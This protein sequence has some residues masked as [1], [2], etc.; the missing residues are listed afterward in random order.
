[1]ESLVNV[2][3]GVEISMHMVSIP[4][5][6]FDT[7]I[8]TFDRNYSLGPVPEDGNQGELG[9]DGNEAEPGASSG[10][11]GNEHMRCLSPDPWFRYYDR[12][13]FNKLLL[14]VRFRG[15]I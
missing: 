14:L 6:G 12:R 5:H 7:V 1:M 2:M 9:V 8:D 4:T 10:R 3:E 11:C 15:W 13:A